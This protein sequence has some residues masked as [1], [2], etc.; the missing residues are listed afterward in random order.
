MERK[1]RILVAFLVIMLCLLACIGCSKEKSQSSGTQSS[2][3]RYK[4][5]MLPQF[6]GENYFDGCRVGAEKAAREFGVELIY[7]G[8]SQNESN[9]ARQVEIVNGFIAQGVDAI[10]A[11]P[12]DAMGIAPKLLEAQSK[13]ITVVTFDADAREDSRNFFVNQAT[14]FD[15]A[16]GLIKAIVPDLEKIG[17]GPNKPA[18]LAMLGTN[19]TDE[20]TNRWI[21]AVKEYCETAE[22]GKYRWITVRTDA[23]GYM[24]GDIWMPG[25]DETVTQQAAEQMLLVSGDASDGSQLN[26]IIGMSSMGGPALGAAYDNFF[27]RKPVVVITGIATPLGLKEYI[28]D[29]N[30]PMNA[31]V[32][33]DVGNLGYLSVEATVD[34]LD[35]KLDLNANTYRSRLGEKTILTTEVDIGGNKVQ[36]KEILLGTAL[37]FDKN[38]VND[39]DF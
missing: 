26:A 18:R 15:L 36:A 9:N 16:E 22:N 39:F 3:A 14:P 28:L 31:G 6:L 4:I 29:S 2:G 17:F 32:L 35:K 38:N 12:I 5:A 21:Y 25:V 13:G 1:K 24:G 10:I 8:P 7:D 37:I 11:S 20:N 23:S 34:Y 33:W 30:N 27:G 19:G